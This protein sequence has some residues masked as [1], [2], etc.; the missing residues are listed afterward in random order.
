MLAKAGVFS[1]VMLAAAALTACG[2]GSTTTQFTRISAGAAH[3]CALRSDGNVVCWGDDDRG[4]LRAPEHERFTAIAAGASHTCGLRSD[5][6]AAC[7]GYVLKPE[8]LLV[9]PTFVQGGLF[10]PEDER[11]ASIAANAAAT[12]GLRAEGNVVCWEVRGIEYLPFGT[13]RF[14]EISAG[15]YQV[16]GLRSD[17]GVLCEPLGGLLAPPEGER[18]V[19]IS[20]A[21]AHSCGLRSDGSVLCWGADIAG[22][23]SAPEDGRFS[24]I[25][26]GRHHTCALRSDGTPVCWGYD[27]EGWAERTSGSVPDPNDRAGKVLLDEE[28]R[29][30]SLPLSGP[31][32]GERFTAI[33]AGALHACGLR[34][35]GGISCWGSDE[36][37]QASPPSDLE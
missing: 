6:S 12:C 20:T 7:W 21:F 13:E 10:P 22:Q 2:I 9:L 36:H 27:F 28:E 18:F 33:T 19:S 31:P 8:E 11:L 34:E 32:E 30:R 37:G 35:D 5:G 25:A 24:A 1:L 4:Q 23:L 16:C 3:T 15:G 26:A 17:G 14:E 29:L